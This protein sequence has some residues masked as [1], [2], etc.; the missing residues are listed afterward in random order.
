MARCRPA[1]LVHPGRH[2]TWYGDDAQRSRAIALLNALLGSWGRRGGF[3]SQAS[4]DVPDYP[5]P[6][7][8]RP[9]RPKVDNPD[10]RYPFADG[11]LTTGIR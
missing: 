4:M 8:P 10:K 5:Y 9:A 7:Y 1:T 11:A 3:Y 6:D 2:V